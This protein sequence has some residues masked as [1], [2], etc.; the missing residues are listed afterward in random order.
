MP[1]DTFLGIAV[2]LVVLS[3]VTWVGLWRAIRDRIKTRMAERS[4]HTP[5]GASR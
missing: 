4:Q 3:S 2:I 5:A 1:S